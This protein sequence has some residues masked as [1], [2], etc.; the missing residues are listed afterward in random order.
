MLNRRNFTKGVLGAAGSVLSGGA[1]SPVK[2][3]FEV[4][5]SSFLLDG[6]PFS[7][8]SGEMHPARIPQPYWRD[9]L[10]MAHA[11]GLNT[12]SIYVFWNLVEPEPGRFNF[13]GQADVASFVR[14]ARDEGLWVILRPGPYV[15]AEWEFGGMP[16]WL[17][18]DK[19]MRVRT[20]NK[21]F[22]AAAKGYT[23]ELGRQLAPLDITRGGP[24]ILVQVENEYGSYAGDHT[25]M[26]D[27]AAMTRTAGFQCPLFTNNGGGS[28]MAHGSLPGILPGLDGGTGPDIMRQLRPYR[29]HGPWFVPES[30]TGW[31][32]HWGQ[33]F[34]RVATAAIVDQTKWKLAHDVS[35]SY[36]MV[37]GGTTFGFMSGA[38][39]PVPQITSYDY[40]APIDESGRPTKKYFA[41]RNV[42]LKHAV[43]GATIPAV[44]KRPPTIEIPSITLGEVCPLSAAMGKPTAAATPKTMEELNQGYGYVLYR[45]RLRGGASGVLAIDKLRDFALVFVNSKRVAVLDRRLGQHSC[46]LKMP[47]GEATLD[48]LVENCGRCNY[49]YACLHDVRKGIVGRVILGGREL[50]GWE[51]YTLPM[52][53]PPKGF[54]PLLHPDKVL[55]M[56]VFR[57]GFFNLQRTGDTFLDM[58]PWGKGIVFVNG[59]NLGRYW[60]IGP[61]QTLYL[62]GC[63]LRRGRNEIVVFE[64]LRG[65]P[66]RV[67]GIRTPILD[68]LGKAEASVAG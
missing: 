25:Y 27:I 26:R 41:L 50:R 49:G 62:P 37:H 56:P 10:R 36:Y 57:R 13:L 39:G 55:G 65:Q 2:H 61:Q 1:T 17:L 18:K 16:W 20:L 12:V 64:M 5:H 14:M 66:L 48:I 6:K 59:H 30:Y 24:I 9:R 68:K 21:A 40:D 52:A 23:I 43:R 31:L 60:H 29:P 53:A 34:V 35:F 28:M 44:P 3:T 45:T 7:I 42:L 19:T 67:A 46:V 15:C 4:G 11:M 22:L 63:W 33:P 51:M 47:N 8:R 58:R 32:D 54:R 38:N